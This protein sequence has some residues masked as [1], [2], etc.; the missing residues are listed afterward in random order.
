MEKL[1]A[2]IPIL[3]SS[4]VS[5]N[6]HRVDQPVLG[7]NGCPQGTA[8]VELSPDRQTLKVLAKQYVAEAGGA[9][10]KTIDR[11]ICN[12]TVPVHAPSGFSFELSSAKFKG[13]V[14]LPS[15]AKSNLTAS[16]F[17][18]GTQ[19]STESKEFVGPLNEDYLVDLPADR[20]VIHKTP[21]GAGAN[22]RINSSI[23]VQ[24]N[25]KQ[26]PTRMQVYEVVDFTFR[27]KQCP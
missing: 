10:N 1:L 25:K 5:A 14:T 8:T 4:Y 27:L 20:T 13:H 18:A 21:C 9:T 19:G 15:G 2:L 17:H 6:G 3:M 26:E 22:L 16:V 12:I 24:T 11:Q 7:G 23:R